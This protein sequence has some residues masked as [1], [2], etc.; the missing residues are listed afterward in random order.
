M[1]HVQ[2][3]DAMFDHPKMLRVSKDAK[4]LAVAAI[5]YCGNQLTDGFI[6]AG[7]IAV[8]GAR[9]GVTKTRQAIAE[10]LEVRL[11]EVAEGG[12]RAHDYLAY[13]A[14]AEKV[15]ANKEAARARMQRVR[16][17]DVRA[18]KERTSGEVREPTTTTTTTTTG[19]SEPYGSREPET[20]VDPH[21]S[22]QQTKTHKPQSELKPWDVLETLCDALG[23]ST[24]DLSESDRG[25]QL[26]AAKRLL[27]DGTTL[28]EVTRVTAW[29]LKQSWITAGV[30]LPLIE[31]QIGRWRVNGRPDA[32]KPSLNGIRLP[33]H[34]QSR[35]DRWVI[36]RQT[37]KLPIEPYPDALLADIEAWKASRLVGATL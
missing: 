29:L 34:L 4:I 22:K 11:W 32:P 1:T 20:P 26:A 27:A 28:D 6:P 30:D 8:L 15:R 33:S 13:N 10:L 12:Y 5:C 14:S 16:S 24:A 31:K 35:V 37:L 21:P 17:G 19:S 2:I 18:N 25:R 3:D 7:A 9:T 23:T 36:E